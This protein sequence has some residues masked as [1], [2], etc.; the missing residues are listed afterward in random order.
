[1][2]RESFLDVAVQALPPAN[3]AVRFLNVFFV[4]L[5]KFFFQNSEGSKPIFTSKYSFDRIFQAL[6]DLRTSAPVSSSQPLLMAQ[7]PASV[8]QLFRGAISSCM[9]LVT[10]FSTARLW[11]GMSRWSAY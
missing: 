5:A 11:E 1:M 8:S 10:P 9:S 3:L 6:Q 7:P 2:L 4:N